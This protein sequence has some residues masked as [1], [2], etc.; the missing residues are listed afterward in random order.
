MC[1]HQAH[2]KLPHEIGNLHNF[3]KNEKN[4]IYLSAWHFVPGVCRYS[5]FAKLDAFDP[6]EL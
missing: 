1:G 5:I 3:A 2:P 6:K 4:K